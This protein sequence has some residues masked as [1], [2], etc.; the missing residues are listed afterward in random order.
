MFSLKQIHRLQPFG[1]MSAESS[2]ASRPR[3]D[4]VNIEL[5]FECQQCV[6]ADPDGFYDR[7]EDFQQHMFIQNGFLPGCDNTS[8][9]E[10]QMLNVAIHPFPTCD[11]CGAQMK[12]VNHVFQNRSNA[13]GGIPR[14]RVHRL[15]VTD[16]RVDGAPQ[17]RARSR[18]AS[19]QRR[20][21]GCPAAESPSDEGLKG[22]AKSDP[23]YQ[24]ALID[25]ATIEEPPV[26]SPQQEPQQK[27]AHA[28]C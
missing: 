4:V 18:P 9:V 15:E 6:K 5:K 2:E 28:L 25:G 22:P 11:R 16:G 24:E 17:Q 23:Y 10:L 1:H 21:C 8:L 27:R 3:V 7:P 19:P 26:K 20:A 12:Y 13:L 14:V